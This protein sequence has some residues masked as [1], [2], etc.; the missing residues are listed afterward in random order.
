MTEPLKVQLRQNLVKLQEFGAV[1]T[2]AG[3]IANK[4]LRVIGASAATVPTATCGCADLK[5]TKTAPA[6][7]K[8]TRKVVGRQ[9]VVNL[10][11]GSVL[12]IPAGSQVTQLAMD[13]IRVN[14]I[15]LVRE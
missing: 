10:P 3:K 6:A 14:R 5:K 11:A 9:D 1:L 13:I 12:K 2:T 15:Q 4:T 7:A 8:V